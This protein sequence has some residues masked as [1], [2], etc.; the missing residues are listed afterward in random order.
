MENNQKMCLSK[1]IDD[2]QGKIEK[3]FKLDDETWRAA[4]A[5]ED[6]Y[7]ETDK[8]LKAL[9]AG[10]QKR[11]GRRLVG[12]LTLVGI[13]AIALDAWNSRCEKREREKAEKENEIA[14]LKEQIAYLRSIMETKETNNETAG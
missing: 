6:R 1:V 7:W 12:T 8:R 11:R 4:L 10:I 9:E 14:D 3:L 13:G 2:M 5:L